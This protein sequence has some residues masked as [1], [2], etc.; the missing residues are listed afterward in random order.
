MSI[1][2]IR[3]HIT[4]LL[5]RLDVLPTVPVQPGLRTVSSGPR[6]ITGLGAVS[7]GLGM[8]AR[9]RVLGPA[10]VGGVMRHE[11]I[12]RGGPAVL[13]VVVVVV[14]SGGSG[15]VGDVIHRCVDS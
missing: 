11:G 9:G 7:D 14:L 13:A 2:V 12:A 4:L 6:V 1:A 3:D 5:V 10:A 15:I 8:V